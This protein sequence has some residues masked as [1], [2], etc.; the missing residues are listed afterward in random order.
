MSRF[1]ENVIDEFDRNR[2]DKNIITSQERRKQGT[3][4]HAQNH[5]RLENASSEFSSI[6]TA[7]IRIVLEYPTLTYII[8]TPHKMVHLSYFILCSSKNTARKYIAFAI[9]NNNKKMPKHI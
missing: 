3:K 8:Y 6:E 4:G 5:H 2:I 7:A 1:L 9:N